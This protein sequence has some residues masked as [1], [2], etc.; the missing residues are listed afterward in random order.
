MRK[1]SARDDV[2]DGASV[3]S[4]SDGNFIIKV[5]AERAVYLNI[6]GYTGSIPTSNLTV[7]QTLDLGNIEVCGGSNAGSGQFSYNGTTRQCTATNGI[8][9]DSFCSGF[10]ETIL[11]YFSGGVSEQISLKNSPV[12]NSGTFNILDYYSNISDC[13]KIRADYETVT[14]G[15][16]VHY[17]S[18]AGSITKTSANSLTFTI[19]FVQTTNQAN[20]KIVTGS[21]SY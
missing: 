8:N 13:T 4:N 14:S 5:P 20:I 1:I 3:I 2:G 11:S 10:S 19:T 6:D 7:D 15:N 9:N 12:G 21:C 16:Y 18:T 17:V